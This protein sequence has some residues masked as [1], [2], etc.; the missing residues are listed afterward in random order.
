MSNISF[1]GSLL[2]T[3]NCP[4]F[5]HI[6]TGCIHVEYVL[7]LECTI[8]CAQSYWL[9]L[10]LNLSNCSITYN[11]SLALTAVRCTRSENDDELSCELS[12]TAAR[13]VF[14]GSSCCRNRCR[15]VSE[16]SEAMSNDLKS[17]SILSQQPQE[18]Q[19]QENQQQP[20]G[21]GVDESLIGFTPRA[22][23]QDDSVEILFGEEPSSKS[24]PD[25]PVEQVEVL[26]EMRRRTKTE[27]WSRR[28][29]A[30]VPRCTSQNGRLSRLSESFAMTQNGERLPR[31][32]RLYL[33]M[34]MQ[35]CEQESL[36]GWLERDNA[37]IA[38]IL[39]SEQQPPTPT[40]SLPNISDTQL[41]AVNL[42]N[43]RFVLSLF[44]QVVSAISYI[45]SQGLI[46]RDL[47]A[48]S[49]GFSFCLTWDVNRLIG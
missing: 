22:S 35:L 18:L 8:L 36:H 17:S 5:I 40:T 28:S 41:H 12:S 2:F 3:S 43:R 25:E 13:S 42:R 27:S 31:E 46:H 34:Q 7:L 44:S 48:R 47:K 33:Y 6:D 9:E 20:F 30:P 11:S 32:P 38:Q 15:A 21:V 19:E 29:R 24:K 10:R 4:V 23:A 37:R 26:T 16:R 49:L 1:E 14:P 45:H 39:E